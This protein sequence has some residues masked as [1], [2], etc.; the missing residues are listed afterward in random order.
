MVLL[1]STFNSSSL[2]LGSHVPPVFPLSMHRLGYHS[3]SVFSVSLQH[4]DGKHHLQ[5]KNAPSPYAWISFFLSGSS[6]EAPIK[7]LVEDFTAVPKEH[8]PEAIAGLDSTDGA[9]E[10]GQVRILSKDAPTVGR[11]VSFTPQK[12]REMRKRMRKIESFHDTMYHSAIAAR[13]AS[14]DD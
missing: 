10:A 13:L 1:H 8:A 7:P 5:R 6:S 12:A 4:I 11:R 2:V 14:Q 9:V 3:P